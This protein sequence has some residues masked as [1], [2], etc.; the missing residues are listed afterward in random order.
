MKKYEIGVIGGGP[1][2]YHAALAAAR[3][4]NSVLL[5]EKNKPGGVCLYE[6]C[7]P[8]K[9]FIH[10]VRDYDDADKSI[11]NIID[12]IRFD[13]EQAKLKKER[14]VARLKSGLLMQL[15]TA[16]V[17]IV[18][19]KGTIIRTDSDGVFL[20]AGNQEIKVG[21][22]IIATGSDIFVPDIIGLKECLATSNRVFDSTSMLDQFPDIEELIIL[23][24]GVIGLEFAS[25]YSHLG[26][27]IV[28]IEKEKDFLPQLTDCLKNEYMRCIK[29]KGVTLLLAHDTEQVSCA[30]DKIVVS[31]IDRERNDIKKD[32]QA[33][34]LL[35]ATGR[36]P[37]LD[38]GDI[39]DLG[40]ILNCGHIS[41]DLNGQ[42][43]VE[44]VYACGDVA[45]KGMLAYTAALE[46]E[47]AVSKIIGRDI[48][49]GQEPIPYVI[50]S[51]P[52]VAYVGESEQSCMAK[53]IPFKV[54]KCSMNYSSMYSIEND[55]ENGSFC[56][57]YHENTKRL[58]G[59]HVIGNGSSEIIGTLQSYV[60]M[61]MSLED[62]MNIP[63]VHPSKL[64]VIRE[65]IAN[66]VEIRKKG[67]GHV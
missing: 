42:T 63:I 22:V 39:D 28:I 13:Y 47:R 25:I 11:C 1:G 20:Q 6:G 19:E 34:G 29:R 12:N 58:L 65:A 27:K 62:I 43:S 50:F 33:D 24:A 38:F 10:S 61:G 55:K 52:E 60:K 14:D 51:N 41:T 2:G 21:S 18:N 5:I 37:V 59:C 15:K 44:H 7:I 48:C 66:Y 46:G 40:I 32:L 23:G 57:V 30:N 8:T 54:V 4:G 3:Q 56:I 16:G 35:V 17:E 26:K 64:E 9:S 67:R 31:V 49:Q 45:D 36:K 53:G